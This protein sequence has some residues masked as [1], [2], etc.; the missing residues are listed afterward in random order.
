[1]KQAGGAL[2]AQHYVLLMAAMAALLAGVFVNGCLW[3]VLRPTPRTMIQEC[4]FF[5]LLPWALTGG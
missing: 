4:R 5:P 2:A 3:H 1:M